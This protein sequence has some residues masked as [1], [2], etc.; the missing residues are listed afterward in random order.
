MEFLN[1]IDT[2]LFLRLNADVANGFF[3]LVMPYYTNIHY[4]RWPIIVSLAALA[5]FGGGKGRS[6]VLM[7][8][9]TLTIT[10]QLSSTYL[11]PWIGRQRPCHV[12]EGA[13]FITGCGH[14]LS[15]PSGHATNTMAAA[16]LFGLLY[17][18]LL[19]LLLTLSLT[20][21]YSRIYLGIHYPGDIL[22]G[23]IVGGTIA[24]GVVKLYEHYLRRDLERWLSFRRRG[25]SR[26]GARARQTTEDST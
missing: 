11:K 22:V 17:R 21:S 7:A 24:Y 1:T 2:W 10:D 3:D 9:I 15:M 23:W 4:W 26:S 25:K 8:L 18:R 13:R 19:I 6:V 16:I 5:V 12:V 20:V 14:S